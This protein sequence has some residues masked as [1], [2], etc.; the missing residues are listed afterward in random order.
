MNRYQLKGILISLL[1]IAFIFVLGVDFGRVFWITLVILF[2]VAMLYFT[3]GI[4]IK[5]LSRR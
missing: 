4:A 5:A 3:V 1:F 2:V